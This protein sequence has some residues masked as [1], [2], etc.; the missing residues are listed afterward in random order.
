M[1]PYLGY[2]KQ[3]SS[4]HGG[5]DISLRDWFHFLYTYRHR[6]EIAR[7]HDSSILTFLSQLYTDFHNVCTNLHFHQ[8]CSRVPFSTSSPTLNSCYLKTTVL[9]GVRGNFIEVLIWISLMNK[10]VEHV[11]IC[12]LEIPMS[13]MKKYI[14]KHFA[15]FLTR[16]LPLAI[17]L[18]GFFIYFVFY[19]RIT[20]IDCKYFHPFH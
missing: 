7:T 16:I 17:E 13:S 10:D 19:T 18:Y 11:F 20:Y 6:S 2:Y 15:N 3:C 4:E 14:F 1:V 8:L 12:M 9:T 5:A